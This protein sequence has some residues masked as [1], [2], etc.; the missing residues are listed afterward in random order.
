MPLMRQ[1]MAVGRSKR[2]CV[3][4]KYDEL[5]V[6]TPGASRSHG[7]YSTGKTDAECHHCSQG[8]VLRASSSSKQGDRLWIERYANVSFSS[9][10]SRIIISTVS[11]KSND[12]VA[13]CLAPGRRKWKLFSSS[14][15]Q[16]RDFVLPATLRCR[17]IENSLSFEYY[18]CGQS[19]WRL[20]MPCPLRL[21][22]ID[23]VV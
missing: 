1:V 20:T 7:A 9:T 6:E 3:G 19:L 23:E 8:P 17:C 18:N 14:W 15:V 11:T 2:S 4:D 13:L 12:F 16:I 21:E 5:G 10:S 22:M